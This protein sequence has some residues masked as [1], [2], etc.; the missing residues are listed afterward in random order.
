MIRGATEDGTFVFAGLPNERGFLG[1]IVSEPFD[2][3]SFQDA[4]AKAH[5]ALSPSLSNWATSRCSALRSSG[6]KRRMRTGNTQTSILNPHFA[7][8]L[9][10]RPTANLLPEFAA[11]RVC[12]ARFPVAVSST[13]KN[14]TDTNCAHDK[15][16]SPSPAACLFG[17][18]PSPFRPRLL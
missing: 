9:A 16:Q 14:T 6:R 8:P 13:R 3:N 15:T 1:K 12:T 11:T 4:A 17:N 5:R 7:V 18:Q 10:I 2:A